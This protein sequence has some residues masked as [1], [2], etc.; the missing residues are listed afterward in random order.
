MRGS[1]TSLQR[2]DSPSTSPSAAQE[3]LQKLGAA[4]ESVPSWRAM[5]QTLGLRRLQDLIQVCACARLHG[6]RSM[7]HAVRTRRRAAPSLPARG[8]QRSRV[9]AQPR[10]HCPG[11]NGALAARAMH[12]G[13]VLSV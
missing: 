6:A 13:H 9:R 4:S 10:Q 12:T 3:W 2:S 7:L 8:A 1:M 5:S 11:T